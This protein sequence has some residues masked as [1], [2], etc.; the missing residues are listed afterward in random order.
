MCPTEVGWSSLIGDQ[1]AMEFY[2]AIKE[3]D[4]IGKHHIIRNKPDSENKYYIFSL[5]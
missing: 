1:L 5:I 3:I 2:S 4:G